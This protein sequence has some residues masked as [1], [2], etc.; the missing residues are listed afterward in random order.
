M[1]VYAIKK[2][3]PSIAASLDKGVDEIE[4]SWMKYRNDSVHNLKQA[5]EDEKKGQWQAEGQSVLFDA[6]KENVALQ[7]EAAYRERLNTAYKEVKQ[8]L[9]YQLETS[10]VKNRVEHKHMVNWI[11]NG[12]RSSITP[13]QESAA[14]KQ[15]IADLKG[16]SKA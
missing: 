8:R 7:L 9:D 12:V 16:L 13:A 3:G 1:V 5:I 4:E 15:C 11:I 10:N 2:F 14:L 6:K